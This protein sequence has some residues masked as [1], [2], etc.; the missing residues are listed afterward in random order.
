VQRSVERI[1]TTHVGS[2]PRSADVVDAV[3]GAG[4]GGPRR[5]TGF[6]TRVLQ[7]IADVVAKGARLASDRLWPS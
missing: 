2:L 5:D 3:A 6:A 7:A 4:R 1:L